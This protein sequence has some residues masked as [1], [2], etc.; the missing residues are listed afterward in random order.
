MRRHL[1]ALAA[2]TAGV[3]VGAAIVATRWVVADT[4]VVT[5]ALLRYAI[6]AVALVPFALLA[7]TGIA[8]RDLLPVGALGVAQ[9]A[10]VILLM[11]YALEVLPAARVALLFATTPLLAMVLERLLE[12]RPFSLTR[13]AAIALTITGV[14]LALAERPI[15]ADRP[16]WSSDAAVL[17]SAFAAALCGIL[18]RPYLRRYPTV[19]IGAVAMLA[20]VFALLGVEVEAASPPLAAIRP[21]AW[22][23]VAGIGL[24][25]ALGYFVWLWALKSERA[26]EVTM[27]LAL[28]PITA[29]LLGVV[30]LAEP[31]TTRLLGGVLLV[32]AGLWLAQR[33]RTAA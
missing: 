21:E 6:G 14:F 15:A 25:S 4:G 12:R 11:N 31:L 7:R 2:A 33:A 13:L 1:P 10:V 17:G 20:S 3:Q 30:L 22:A 23:V 18:Y 8:T 28:S 16:S 26:T 24:S 9:F 19:T 29:A 27:F 32:T 5:L